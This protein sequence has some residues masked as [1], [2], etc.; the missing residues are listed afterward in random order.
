MHS[1]SATDFERWA[2]AGYLTPTDCARGRP[3]LDAVFYLKHNIFFYF[4]LCVLLLILMHDTNQ[5][6]LE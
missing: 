1:S 5:I 4:Q 6:R 3:Q 2:G